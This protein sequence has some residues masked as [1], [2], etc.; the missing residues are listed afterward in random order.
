MNLRSKILLFLAAGLFACTSV[1][2]QDYGQMT[3]SFT[4]Y[5]DTPTAFTRPPAGY[6]PFY[7]S[8]FCRHGSRYL[9]SADSY[10]TPLR[11]LEEADR[12]GFLTAT[13]KEL[14]ADVRKMAE[15]AK[16]K[17]G[18]LLPR[19][20]REHRH[21]MERIVSRYP[22]IFAGKD[23]RVDVYSSQ[24]HR[25]ML[26]MAYS[27]DAITAA[28]PK[29]V[30]DRH[31]SPFVQESIFNTFQAS[32]LARSGYLQD[33][34][35]EKLEH[36]ANDALLDRIFT[37][38]EAQKDRY[39]SP[40]LRKTLPM[41]L[42]KLSCESQLFDE[43]GVNL[44]KEYFTY[45]DFRNVW[46]MQNRIEHYGIGPSEE[47]GEFLLDQASIPLTHIIDGAEEAIAGGPYRAALRYGHDSQFGPLAAL[48]LFEG[49]CTPAK[50]PLHPE[51]DW[52]W[53]RIC[54]MG[55]NIQLVFFQKKGSGDILV[56]ALLNEKE[57]HLVGIGT[58]KWPFY[59]WSDVKAAYEERMERIPDF[60]RGGWE[61][62]TVQE[63][64]VYKRFSGKDPISGANQIVNAVDVD[65]N[66]PRYAVKFTYGDRTATSDAF[67]NAGA[68]AT[69][70][71]TYEKESVFIRVDG[72]TSHKIDM[73]IVPYAGSVPQWKTDSSISTDGRKVT[74]SYTGKGLSLDEQ[75]AA[76][77]AIPDPN[78]FTSAPML[79]EDSVPVGK[80]FA[81]SSLTPA[82]IE[83]LSYEDPL[84]HQSV[85][86][87]RS[88]AALTADNHLILIVVDGRRP[89]LAE[90]MNAFEL[91]SFIEEHFHP[92]NAINLDGGGSTA[93]CVKGEGHPETH[94]VNYPSA[95]RTFLHDKERRIPTHIHILDLGVNR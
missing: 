63:G 81:T 93:L 19:G 83:K 84:R 5:H 91:T 75:R 30:Y 13:G 40:E 56:K 35:A 25:C 12:G 71:A 2:A 53:D 77:E 92:V 41:Y 79:I 4:P 6:K 45:E 85:R 76:F 34:N 47:Y 21:I 94:V 90:G 54:P 57:M 22:E 82:Q 28:N 33:Y 27:L 23:C 88:A 11:V 10:D 29:V 15:D 80:Y 24:S 52:V 14:L 36:F 46:Q 37:Y 68:V 73:D 66:N 51:K 69:I 48:M 74:I 44:F 43:L 8:T 70:N 58:D 9:L 1:C 49:C 50:D 62:D 55:A 16:G 17:Y 7:L 3:S 89:G 72:T 26:S 86:H 31:S 95:S 42:W 78:V 65:L 38:D 67:K 18:T 87:P 39:L 20:G 61:V 60:N 64:L 32:W 59:H